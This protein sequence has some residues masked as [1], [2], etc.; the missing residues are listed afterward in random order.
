MKKSSEYTLTW[1]KKNIEK[2]NTYQ[3]NWRQKSKKYS[4][5]VKK[6]R[7]KRRIRARDYRDN[8]LERARSIERFQERRRRER[9]YGVSYPTWWLCDGCSKPISLWRGEIYLDHDH[10]KGEFRSWI[11][12]RCNTGLGWLD[13]LQNWQIERVLGLVN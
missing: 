4:S 11:C 9:K 5:W 6:N 3:K 8:D 10:K 2:W 13:G 12:N 7:V 1:R